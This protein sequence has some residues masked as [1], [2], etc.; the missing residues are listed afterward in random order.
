MKDMDE[1]VEGLTRLTEIVC[2]DGKWVNIVE[3][4]EELKN[5]PK[6]LELA[7]TVRDQMDYRIEERVAV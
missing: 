1:I 2:R 3:L 7:V 4:H 6:L 5:L